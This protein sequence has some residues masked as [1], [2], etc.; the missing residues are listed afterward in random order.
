M[1]IGLQLHDT[2]QTVVVVISPQEVLPVRVVLMPRGLQ[3]KRWL[4]VTWPSA[5]LGSGMGQGCMPAA[6][7][8]HHGTA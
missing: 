1:P 5:V 6:A 4:R 7:R 8:Y 3:A 2:H